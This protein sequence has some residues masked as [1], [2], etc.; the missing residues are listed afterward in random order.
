M[1]RNVELFILLA[2]LDNSWQAKNLFLS[3]IESS[4]K[5]ILIKKNPFK[6]YNQAFSEINLRKK[7]KSYAHQAGL[8]TVYSVLLLYYAYQRT[9]TPYWAKHI[10]LGAIGYFIAPIDSIPDLTPLLGYTDD[11]GVLSF[12]LVTIASYVNMDV[13][14]DARKK[15]KEWFGAFDL[16]DLKDIDNRL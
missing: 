7:L 15:L 8:K 2:V 4:I 5:Y 6:R 10:V 1:K 9:E 11:L 16:Q 14:I 3:H 12:G 13:K